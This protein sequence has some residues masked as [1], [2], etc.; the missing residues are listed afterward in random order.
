MGL[1]E[2]GWV[3]GGPVVGESWGPGFLC[4]REEGLGAWIPWSEGGGDGSK[5]LG[6]REEPWGSGPLGL[7]EEV[8]AW[9]PGSEGEGGQRLGLLGPGAEGL[10]GMVSVSLT[11]PC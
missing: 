6:L 2:W 11:T 9:T 4:L 3:L 5:V 7:S 8:R 10:V 1:K